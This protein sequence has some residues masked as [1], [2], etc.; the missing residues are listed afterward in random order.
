M[1]TLNQPL[2][3]IRWV[4]TNDFQSG[5]GKS[6]VPKLYTRG[7]A[8]SVVGTYNKTAIEHRWPQRLEALPV[9]VT[10]VEPT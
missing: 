2:F 10:L 1:S 7:S 3:L 8:N 4:G 9:T 6:A 5:Y